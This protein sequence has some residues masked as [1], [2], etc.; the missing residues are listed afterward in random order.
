MITHQEEK[1][2]Q[3]LKRKLMTVIGHIEIGRVTNRGSSKIGARRL[4]DNFEFILY[5]FKE[6]I[7]G[8]NK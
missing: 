4:A 3:W 5:E 1:A 6:K 2:R 8:L 7:K